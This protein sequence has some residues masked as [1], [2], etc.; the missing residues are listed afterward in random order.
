MD[1]QTRQYPHSRG[2][3]VFWER[4]KHHLCFSYISP[5]TPND[6]KNQWHGGDR[7]HHHGTYRCRERQRGHVLLGSGPARGTAK[8]VTAPFGLPFEVCGKTH[9]ICHLPKEPAHTAHRRMSPCCVITYYMCTFSP[10]FGT[11]FSC[12]AGNLY[13]KNMCYSTYLTYHMCQTC[14]QFT[15]KQ[16]HM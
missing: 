8:G 9:Y 16:K 7:P 5:Y 15:E 2:E 6:G 4:K 10:A 3:N 1:I 13:Y 14:M 11:F 12:F